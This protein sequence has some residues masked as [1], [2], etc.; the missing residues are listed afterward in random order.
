MQC[1]VPQNRLLRVALLCAGLAARLAAGAAEPGFHWGLNGEVA[2]GYL[3]SGGTL[4]R[5]PFPETAAFVE[6]T[7]AAYDR[8]LEKYSK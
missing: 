2:S 5:V 7:L 4:T 1:A 8:Y 3:S 6:K